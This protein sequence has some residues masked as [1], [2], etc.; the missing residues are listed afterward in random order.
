MAE[1][2]LEV[3]AQELIRTSD[4]RRAAFQE[5]LINTDAF[6]DYTQ[7]GALARLKRSWK[8]RVQ[9]HGHHQ[10]VDSEACGGGTG[11]K[12]AGCCREP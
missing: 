6:K 7:R 10:P 3:V 2:L 12:R 8:V 1:S 9:W 11:R 4:G 5:I